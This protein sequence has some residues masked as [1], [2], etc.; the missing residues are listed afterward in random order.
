MKSFDVF[1][2][3]ISWGESDGKNRPV[4]AFVL[5]ESTVDVYRITTKYASKSEAIR[6][7]YFKIDDWT[8]CGLSTESYVDVGTLITLPMQVL[9]NKVPIGRLTDSDKRRFLVFLN[10]NLQGFNGL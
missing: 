8:E 2:T 1:V 3:H 5:G 10:G 7:N 4:L 6:E 9:N